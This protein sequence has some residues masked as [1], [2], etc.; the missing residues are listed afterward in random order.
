MVAMSM[1]SLLLTTRV[2]SPFTINNGQLAVAP[3][4]NGQ[5]LTGQS[6]IEVSPKISITP[7]VTTAQTQTPAPTR[8]VFLRKDKEISLREEGLEIKGRLPVFSGLHGLDAKLNDQINSIY[9][10]KISRAKESKARSITFRYE[11]VESHGVFSILIYSSTLTATQ[12]AEVNSINFDIWQEQMVTVND[13][14]G[15]NGLQLANKVISYKIKNSPERYYPNFPGLQENNAF[16][17][18][19]DSIV[20]LFDAFQIAPG[21]YGIVKISMSKDLVYD[22]RASKNIDFWIKNDSYKLK[23]ISLRPICTAFEYILGWN[24]ATQSITLQRQGETEISM[25]L[26]KNNYLCAKSAEL[27]SEKYVKSVLETSPVVIDGVTYVPISFFD[28]VLDMV[29][30]AAI[31]DETILF[32]TYL[33]NKE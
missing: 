18:L 11:Y 32:S 15:V 24:V 6:S 29:A 10:Q 7:S 22:Y 19:G 5:S 16:E 31:D 3:F 21:S 20:F 12:K 1:L 28:Q 27:N 23:M 14:L 26:G 17:Y 33:I 9:D 2:V 13:I 25:N 30:Y 4:G 8:P